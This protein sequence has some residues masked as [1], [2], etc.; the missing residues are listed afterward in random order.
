MLIN[1][2]LELNCGKS[3]IATVPPEAAIIVPANC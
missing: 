3:K 1:E 2:I